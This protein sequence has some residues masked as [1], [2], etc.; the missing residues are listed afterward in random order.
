M[1][2]L[3]TKAGAGFKETNKGDYCIAELVTAKTCIHLVSKVEE[4]G[5]A[6]RTQRGQLH[7]EGWDLRGEMHQPPKR[8]LRD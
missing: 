4:E 6:T 5:K 8:N 1:M 7:E 2:V 3:F